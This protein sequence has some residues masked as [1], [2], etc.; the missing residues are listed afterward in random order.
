MSQL[1]PGR[2]YQRHVPIRDPLYLKMIRNLPCIA[3]GKF[4]WRIEAMHTGPH[5]LGQKASDLDSLPG[6]HDCHRELHC[7]GPVAFQDKYKISF[8]ALILKLNT[9]YREKIKPEEAA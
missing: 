4:K 8:R 9:F 3:C 1:A 6:C 2:I 5:G 7:I